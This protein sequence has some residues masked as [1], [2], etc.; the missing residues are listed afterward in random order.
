MTSQ[1]EAARYEKELRDMITKPGTIR[2]YRLTA[3]ADF[4]GTVKHATQIQYGEGD[5]HH[6]SD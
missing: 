1:D 4:L 2:I 3:I 6:K 5:V